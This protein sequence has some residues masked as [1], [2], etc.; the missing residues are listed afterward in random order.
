MSLNVG[1][2]LVDEFQMSDASGPMDMLY[3]ATSKFYARA[4]FDVPPEAIEGITL[5]WIGPNLEPF[6]SSTGIKVM[7]TCTPDT[8]PKLDILFFP[9]PFMDY[10]APPDIAA[11]VRRA[12]E[13]TPIVMTVCTG[14]AVLAQLG[15]LDGKRASINAEALPFVKQLYPKVLWQDGVR[16][17]VEDKFWTGGGAV[18]GN[19]MMGGFLKSG[20]FGNMDKIVDYAARVLAFEAKPQYL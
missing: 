16:W 4:G 1:I 8:V 19:S 6:E 7:P 17:T 11:Y 13:E 14:S 3:M 9:G 15:I 20:R 18:E 2:V 12:A 5:H 10:V